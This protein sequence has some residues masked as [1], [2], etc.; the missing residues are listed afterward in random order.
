M[1][2]IPAPARAAHAALEAA[3]AP[4]AG[5]ASSKPSPALATP[6]A[7]SLGDIGKSGEVR[8]LAASSSGAWV[9]LCQGTP[10][11]PALVIGSGAGEPIDDVLAHDPS[12]RY[13]VIAQ[14][15]VVTLVDAASG[16]RFDLTAA[17]ADT[18]RS[19]QDH[20]AHR[21]LSFDAAGRALAYLRRRDAATEIVVRSLPEGAE[22]V[23]AAGAGDVH[24]LRLS[25]DGRWVSFEA[26][27]EDT[28]RN[29]RLDWP[30][31]EDTTPPAPCKPALPRLRS[32]AHL[33]RGDAI[34]KAVVSLA[35]GQ[36]RD[37]PGLITPLGRRLLVREADGS[38][39]LDDS[40][41]Q[42]P[43]APA[44]CAGRVL[45]A[46]A[47]REL[48]LVTCVMPKK[49]GKREVWLF[50]PGVAK[51]LRAELYETTTDREAVT[52]TRLAAL[53]PGSE[54][55]LM[56]LQTRELLPLPTGSRVVQVEGG[57]AVIWRGQE[58]YVYDA[59][60]RQEERLAEGVAKN[61]DLMRVGSALLLTPFVLTGP[62]GPV[63]ASPTAQPLALSVSGHV[64]VGSPADGAILGPL[65]WLDARL[66]P[67]DGP[68][69]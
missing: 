28:T 11:A 66:P 10:A 29:G 34:T 47:E 69:R 60:T 57:R 14:S 59:E 25:A 35:D 24:R 4:A 42:S 62:S 61:P 20:A 2:F 39:Q 27:R 12:G 43:L 44:A 68:L 9:A 55:R 48:S 32:Y 16:S 40:G 22:R 49:P 8:L 6:V 46:D 38:L 19:R 7:V 5:G 58:L 33:G 63:L 21:S 64:L 1:Q 53:Y 56:D 17:G 51:N 23:F 37:V 26:I 54:S 15:G 50:G 3:P 41:K 13:V 45:F 67:P 31:P 18:R 65:H 30:V 36:V 52:G